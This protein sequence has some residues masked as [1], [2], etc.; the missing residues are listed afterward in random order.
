M[1]IVQ[2]N[3]LSS[4]VKA[5]PSGVGASGYLASI[6][7]GSEL[8][9]VTIDGRVLGLGA[10]V[11]ISSASAIEARARSRLSDASGSYA[12]IRDA[13]G[14]VLQVHDSVELCIWEPGETPW[15]AG[16]R[17]NKVVH[18]VAPHETVPTDPIGELNALRVM[19]EGCAGR[20]WITV[21]VGQPDLNPA[22]TV[23]VL[24]R[25]RRA[26]LWSAS[27]G[28]PGAAVNMMSEQIL[29]MSLAVSALFGDMGICSPQKVDITGA[30]EFELY[31]GGQSVGTSDGFWHVSVELEDPR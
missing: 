13:N 25:T 27:A 2:I 26:G 28:G 20:Q 14:D 7:S 4:G 3:S 1:F 17:A 16:R 11:P 24:L 23:Q 21:W 10:V 12:D 18:A 9:Q 31:L 29:P 19:R 6:A 30:V 15:V 5:A 8:D 22:S